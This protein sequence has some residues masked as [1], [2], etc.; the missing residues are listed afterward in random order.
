[1]Y[2][3][4]LSLVPCTPN[5]RHTK[6]SQTMT[7][8]QHLSFRGGVKVFSPKLRKVIKVPKNCESLKT[9]IFQHNGIKVIGDLVK[10]LHYLPITSVSDPDPGQKGS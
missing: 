2:Y 3:C 4:T 5:L 9:V 10:G 7:I 8:N 1:M 6:Y